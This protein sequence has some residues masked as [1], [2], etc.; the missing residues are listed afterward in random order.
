LAPLAVAAALTVGLSGCSLVDEGD[1]LANGK[2][3]FVSKCGACHVLERAGT[4]GVSGPN[5]DAAFRTART[6]GF[7][8]STFQGVVHQQILNPSSSDQVDPKTGKALPGM[9]ANIVTGDDAEDVAAYVASAAGKPG[10]D[11][12]RLA[13]LG[14]KQAE[15]TVKAENGVIELPADPS[16][17]L[18]YSAKAA[19]A[20]A[21]PLTMRSPNE[22]SIPHNIAL[23]GNGVDEV[24]EVVQNGGVSEIEAEVEAGEYT[25]YCSVPGHRE[26]GMQGTLTVK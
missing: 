13:E 20:E 15:G 1:N 16:G 5:L 7:G 10:K 24:G 25:F 4:T 12:G 8:E 17:A 3:Q 6:E 26:G 19:E 22:S 2:E 23:E 18:A 21:G 14:V 9:P 11:G